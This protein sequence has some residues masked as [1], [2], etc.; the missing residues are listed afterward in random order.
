MGGRLQPPLHLR[1]ESRST[2]ADMGTVSAIALGAAL[3]WMSTTR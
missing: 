3:N 1:S 2:Q